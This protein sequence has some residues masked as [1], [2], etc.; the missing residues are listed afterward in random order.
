MNV[1]RNF[2]VSKDDKH[3]EWLLQKSNYR[4]YHYYYNFFNIVRFHYFL[5]KKCNE[6]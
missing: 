5:I 1:A 6:Y 2:K 4:K 3:A